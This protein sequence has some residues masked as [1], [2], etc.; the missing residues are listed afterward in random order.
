MEL[1][2][3]KLTTPFNPWVPDEKAEPKWQTAPQNSLAPDPP[4]PRSGARLPQKSTEASSRNAYWSNY[5]ERK[6]P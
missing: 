3:K 5:Q 6:L 1:V 4:N 2:P